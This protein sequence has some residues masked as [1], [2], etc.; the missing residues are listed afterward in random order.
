MLELKLHQLDFPLLS[1]LIFLPVLG[2][3]LL[4]FI[5]NA[6]TARWI[7][8]AFSIVETRAVRSAAPELRQLHPAHAVRRERCPGSRHGTSTTG[9]VSTGS[10]CCSS[11]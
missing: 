4:L 6:A 5:R 3:F 7:A 1:L 8:L 10:A 11:R 2:A 9:S